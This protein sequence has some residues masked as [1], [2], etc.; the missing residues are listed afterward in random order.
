MNNELTVEE[1][2]KLSL[3]ILDEIDAY[4]EKN[5]IKYFL[6]AG[7]LLGAV[8]HKGY[9]PWDDDL[10]ICMPRPEY[11]RF[12]SSFTSENLSISYYEKDKL[13][14]LPF[15]K[16]YSNKTYGTT[17]K[18]KPL[19]FGLGVDIFPIDG[20]PATEKE[21]LKYFKKQV[22]LFHYFY[23]PCKACEFNEISSHSFFYKIIKY[24]FKYTIF[25][26]LK[27]P[28]FAKLLNK[29]SKKNDFSKSEYAGCSI[30]LYRKK[31]EKVKRSCFENGIKANFEDRQY[32]IPVAYD[33]ILISLYGNS[34]M[35]PPPENQ[36]TTEHIERYFWK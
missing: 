27:S 23:K 9:I 21:T 36:R 5:N 1:R 2:K 7:S 14:V 12:L 13:R 33:D 18:L 22:F 17:P 26:F 28:F 31:L 24:I 4:C 11:E 34:Y 10:D 30:A 16:V 3:E 20:Y 8:R 15:M 29:R 19:P 6:H 35:T 25:I 32:I